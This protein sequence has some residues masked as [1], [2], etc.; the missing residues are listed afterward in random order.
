MPHFAGHLTNRNVTPLRP[1]GQNFLQPRQGDN[2]LFTPRENDALRQRQKDLDMHPRKRFPPPKSPPRVPPKPETP[3][4]RQNRERAEKLRLF[5]M[6]KQATEEAR[7]KAREGTFLGTPIADLLKEAIPYVRRP[8]TP[9]NPYGV[10]RPPISENPAFNKPLLPPN[11]DEYPEPSAIEKGVPRTVSPDPLRPGELRDGFGE[12]YSPFGGTMT[13]LPGFDPNPTTVTSSQGEV[14]VEPGVVSDAHQTFP[15][16]SAGQRIRKQ[17][18]DAAAADLMGIPSSGGRFSVPEVDVVDPFNQRVDPASLP[19]S[20]GSFTYLPQ[21]SEPQSPSNLPMQSAAPES[22]GFMRQAEELMLD[23]MEENSRSPILRQ[24][25]APRSFRDRTETAP[26][27][28]P[29]LANE[30]DMERVPMAPGVNEGLQASL[31]SQYG[32]PNF[33]SRGVM[34]DRLGDGSGFDRLRQQDADR[35]AQHVMPTVGPRYRNKAQEEKVRE[36]DRR[37]RAMRRGEVYTDPVTGEVRDFSAFKAQADRRQERKDRASDILSRA[38]Q[39]R[40]ASQGPIGAA[41]IDPS[42]GIAGPQHVG[43][44]LR[45]GGISKGAAIAMARNEQIQ[46]DMFNKSMERQRAAKRRENLQFMA[47]QGDPEAMLMLKKDA[48]MKVDQA[49]ID[50]AAEVAKGTIPDAPMQTQRLVATPQAERESMAFRVERILNGNLPDERKKKLILDLHG[51]LNTEEGINALQDNTSYDEFGPGD[52]VLSERL[53]KLFGLK[54]PPGMFSGLFGGVPA[55]QGAPAQ[56][57][58]TPTSPGSAAPKP[59]YVD[60]AGRE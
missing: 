39:F 43:R 38:E 46:E 11:P 21:P 24:Q 59:A 60:P 55:P 14:Y 56:Q 3:A 15:I 27:F 37:R 4:Q 23:Q 7:K 47:E 54:K 36:G 30:D 42:G 33:R 50:I 22:R 31:R 41:I 19:A 32:G 26:F 49:D 51:T 1:Q 8:K 17:R 18:Q 45:F 53:R 35:R 58:T 10:E 20:G 44:Q 28:T 9:E 52:Y 13:T 57:G 2:P 48:G 29:G 40:A 25:E 34:S 6:E 5:H 12:P 16:T